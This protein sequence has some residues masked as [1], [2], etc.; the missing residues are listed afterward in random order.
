MGGFGGAPSAPEPQPVPE[1]PQK[2]ATK[3]VS[4]G[5]QA[6]ADAQRDRARKNRGLA[7][8][9]LTSRSGLA[10]GSSTDMNNDTLG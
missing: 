5:A 8:S 6:A 1:A 9:I 3:S 2:L 7:A 4:A 10:S